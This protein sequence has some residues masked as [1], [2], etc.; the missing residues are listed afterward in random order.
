MSSFD[1]VVNQIHGFTVVEL[2]NL[3]MML[4]SMISKKEAEA[5]QALRNEIE[6]FANERGFKLS[7][8]VSSEKNT[9]DRVRK[10]AKIKYRHPDNATL[11]WTGRGRQP[12]WVALFLEN[13][14][15]LEQLSV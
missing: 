13:G 6:K 1:E 7:D 14:G 3:S 11:T 12:K 8:L 5:R 10:P 9:S 2:K 15:Q 4:P